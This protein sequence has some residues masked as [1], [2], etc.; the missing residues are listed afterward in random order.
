MGQRL[1]IQI[2]ENDEVLA[3]AYYHWGAYT[4]SSLALTQMI[5]ENRK[6]IEKAEDSVLYAIRLLES[7]DAL[8]HPDELTTVQNRYLGEYFEPATSRNDGLIAV[9]KKGM[10]NNLGWEE[11]RVELHIDKETVDF[12]VLYIC[13]KESYLNNYRETEEDYQRLPVSSF[14]YNEHEVPFDSFEPFASELIKLIES[15]VYSIRTVNEEVVN[16]VE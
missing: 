16:F 8:L 12:T 10:E 1:N 15:N 3:N 11:G 5:L 9:S 2:V 4:S 7:T 14:D 13:D 6:N